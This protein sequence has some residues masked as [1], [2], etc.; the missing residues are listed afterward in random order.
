MIIV[1]GVISELD[2][3]LSISKIKT[4]SSQRDKK[5]EY[6]ERRKWALF[7][8][9][10]QE[11]PSGFLGEKTFCTFFGLSAAKR[12]GNLLRQLTSPGNGSQLLDN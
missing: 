12:P 2:L 7:A 11:I 4:T 5:T 9:Q 10:I 6:K 3:D 8:A 1:Y